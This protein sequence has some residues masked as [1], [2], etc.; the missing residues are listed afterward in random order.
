MAETLSGTAVP[1]TTV[2][3]APPLRRMLAL[4]ILMAIGS[5]NYVDRQLLS[6][7]I[8]PIRQ[9][10]PLSDTAFGLLTGLCFALFYAS[11]GVPVAMMADR[12]NRVR[13]VAVA[14][15]MWSVCTGFCGFA[16]NF[17][18]LALARFGVGIGE[19][20]GTAPS[21]SILSDYFT[22]EQRPAV[23]G[24]YTVN[25][26]I[27]VFIGI[28]LGGFIA[29]HYGW[30]M[31]F[32]AVAFLGVALAPI[33]WL[34]VREPMRGATEKS[35]AQQVSEPAPSLISTIRIFLKLPTL[36]FLLPASGLLAFVSYGLLNWIPAYLMREADMQLSE[37]SLWFGPAAGICMGLGIWSGGAI[38]N[39]GAKK[40]LTAY[41]WAPAASVIIGIPFLIAAMFMPGWQLSLA[42]LLVP[43]VCIVMYVA[44]ALALTQ[45]LAPLR[46]R[47]TATALLLLSFNLV[48]IGG[49]PL[50]IGIFSDMFTAMGA[51]HSLRWALLS[52]IPISLVAMALY[53]MMARTI[54]QDHA[55]RAAETPA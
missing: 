19:A 52:T 4:V 54:T 15:T 41:A 13:L 29:A 12:I 45:N 53:I 49:G 42:L 26:P 55:T 31:A 28:S 14:C 38:V 33:L 32:F 7:L 37:L 50:M 40:S 6:L 34:L 10:I 27:G 5:I 46:A 3:Q 17:W 23:I 1:S 18:Q 25:G 39:I 24:L 11:M 43:M 44:P 21:L 20:G 22:P 51:E 2:I 9:D 48:G 47:A 35:T 8:E 30:R 16:Q 36:R